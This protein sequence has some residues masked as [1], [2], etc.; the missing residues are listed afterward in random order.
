VTYVDRVNRILAAVSDEDREWLAIHLLPPS[1]RRMER[2]ARRDH[3][4]RELAAWYAE[5]PSGRAIAK[6]MQ[7]D[8][9][10][11]RVGHR[12][13]QPHPDPRD[14]LI[15][16][17]IGLSGGRFPGRSTLCEALSGS[18]DQHLGEAAGHGSRDAP[19]EAMDR[20][21]AKTRATVR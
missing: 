5:E 21:V 18:G 1:L 2:Q 8:L 14:A 19:P 10:R 13:A 3:A 11:Y 7:A 20:P 16:R 4:V 6:R 9:R 17:I 12:V 15:T